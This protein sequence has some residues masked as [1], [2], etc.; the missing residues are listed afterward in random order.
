MGEPANASEHHPVARK[1]TPGRLGATA[2][3]LAIAVVGG[4]VIS[5]SF[6]WS[7]FLAWVTFMVLGPGHSGAAV[8]AEAPASEVGQS[9]MSHAMSQASQY[10]PG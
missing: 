3:I 5:R 7:G 8:T 6:G 1:S 2:A 4:K 10:L 9:P